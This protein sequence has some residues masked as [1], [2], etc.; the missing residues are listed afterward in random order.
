MRVMSDVRE[1]TW[2]VVQGE[3]SELDFDFAGYGAKHFAR[4][5][6]AVERGPFEEWIAA[7]AA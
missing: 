5:R 1:A 7:V 6:D 4:M 2:G 3:M